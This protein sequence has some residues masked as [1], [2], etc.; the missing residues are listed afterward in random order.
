[1]KTHFCTLE[2][3]AFIHASFRLLEFTSILILLQWV[4]SGKYILKLENY[5]KC[6]TNIHINICTHKKHIHQGYHCSQIFLQKI[7]RNHK[8]QIF[9]DYIYL[10][11]MYS[12]AMKVFII[13]HYL[14]QVW[15]VLIGDARI[16]LKMNLKST[17]FEFQ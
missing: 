12:I 8:I 16:F 7:L 15:S 9:S 3:Y 11:T 2:I 14:C 1:M 10:V 17:F 4:R 5:V 6:G 13:F